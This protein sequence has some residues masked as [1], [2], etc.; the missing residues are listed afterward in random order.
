VHVYAPRLRTMNF[1]RIQR[2]RLVRQRVV[3]HSSA[4]DVIA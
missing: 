1:F 3:H 2:G 4:Q